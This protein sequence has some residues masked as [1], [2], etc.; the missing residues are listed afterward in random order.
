MQQIGNAALSQIVTIELDQIDIFQF[1]PRASLVFDNSRDGQLL[2]SIRDDGQQVPAIVRRSIT[3]PSRYEL[4]A[5]ARRLAV[6]RKLNRLGFA[7][8]LMAEVR[9]LSDA[10]AW[11]LAE[12]ENIGRKDVGLL[13]RARNWAAACQ[14]FYGGNQSK[15]ARALGVSQTALSRTLSANNLPEIIIKVLKDPSRLNIH[16]VS[17][18]TATLKSGDAE[19][20]LARAASLVESGKRFS[21]AEAMRHL[22]LTADETQLFEPSPL[23]VNGEV[24]GTWR[25]SLAGD[26]T[27][28][29]KP[30]RKHRSAADLA[31]LFNTVRMLIED[32]FCLDIKV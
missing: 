1:N 25:P 10:Q 26:A 31:D 22:L 18:M 14:E 5:G 8:R 23:L 17:Q 15:M 20:I 9:D 12:I 32:H 6:I 7:I 13:D 3:D 16:F 29:L 28:T 11:Q 2:K 21:C 4:I 24:I 27:L 30:C 19:F